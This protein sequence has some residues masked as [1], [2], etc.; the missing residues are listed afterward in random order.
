MAVG[1]RVGVSLVSCIERG[2]ALASAP[3]E[4]GGLCFT[5][6]LDRA[7]HLFFFRPR[8]QEAAGR[9]SRQQ[10][11]KQ[12]NRTEAE[13]GRDSEKGGGYLGYLEPYPR[14][15]GGRGTSKD[16]AAGRTAQQ[17]QGKAKKT[18]REKEK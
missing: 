17:R 14:A 4:H 3:N 13:R 1:G 5:I 10:T 16:R 11:Q 12:R 2:T 9:N 15:M 6:A 18:T 7:R 8:Q